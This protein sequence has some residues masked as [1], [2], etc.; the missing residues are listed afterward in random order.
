MNFHTKPAATTACDTFPLF[1]RT[2]SLSTAQGLREGILNPRSVFPPPVNGQISHITLIPPGT[3]HHSPLH[4]T[5][6]LRCSMGCPP[7]GEQ[8]LNGPRAPG[9]QPWVCPYTPSETP[10]LQPKSSGSMQKRKDIMSKVLEDSRMR[11]WS[12]AG[13]RNHWTNSRGGKGRAVR[14]Q[15]LQ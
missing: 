7:A 1:P 5:V 10:P 14:P 12:R 11:C 6:A 8:H 2:V 13:R 4:S 3:A 15:E 9:T